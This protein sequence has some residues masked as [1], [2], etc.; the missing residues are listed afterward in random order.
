MAISNSPSALTAPFFFHF[1][2]HTD[3]KKCPFW[4]AKEN[5]APWMK[6]RPIEDT[7]VGTERNVQLRTAT[8]APWTVQCIYQCHR[9]SKATDISEAWCGTWPLTCTD[10][11][12]IWERADS[13]TKPEFLF[14][15]Q[16]SALKENARGILHFVSMQKRR[17]T[18][19]HLF[20]LFVSLANLLKT[21]ICFTQIL[22]S[23]ATIFWGFYFSIIN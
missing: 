15:A 20:H 19:F 1:H 22:R 5:S 7:R 11:R 6:S 3:A 2:F 14:R 16:H 8:S 23:S 12:Q 18:K 10:C 9:S 17:G 4:N 13:Q 21:P